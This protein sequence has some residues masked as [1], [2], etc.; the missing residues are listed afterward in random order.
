M[1]EENHEYHVHNILY[2]SRETTGKHQITSH[3][4]IDQPLWTVAF[5]HCELTLS[6]QPEDFF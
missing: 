3:V 2:S 6:S 1:T 5:L 4:V